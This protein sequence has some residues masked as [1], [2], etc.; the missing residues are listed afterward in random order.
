[1]Y[2]DDKKL[3]EYKQI[4]DI[5]M[6]KTRIFEGILQQRIMDYYLFQHNDLGQDLN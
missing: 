6:K 2:I 3:Q 5:N 4:K 1:M